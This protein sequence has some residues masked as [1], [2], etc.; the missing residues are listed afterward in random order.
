VSQTE[1]EK[2]ESSDAFK[3]AAVNWGIGRFLYDMKI[4]YV[5]A[6]EKK[7]ANNWPYVVNG[8]ARVWDLTEFVERQRSK[9]G[10]S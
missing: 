10:K 9:G 2:G 7:T 4:A 3:R 5:P 6:N 8:S 1:G